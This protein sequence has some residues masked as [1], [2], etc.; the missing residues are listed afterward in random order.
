MQ[1][2]LQNITS[3]QSQARQATRRNWIDYARGIAIILVVFKHVTDG[4]VNM[5]ADINL[6][7]YDFC[8]LFYYARMPL[9][10]V[11]SGIYI[12]KSFEKRG[13]PGFIRYKFSTILY[14]YLVWATLQITFQLVANRYSVGN[15][16]RTALD[17]LY[18]FYQPHQLDQFWFLYV[19]FTGAVLFALLQFYFRLGKSAM[20]L[21]GTATYILFYYLPADFFVFGIKTV[22]KFLFYIALG[23]AI[24][25]T[26]LKPEN[27][28]KFSSLKLTA[29]FIALF[30]ALKLVMNVYE[31]PEQETDF[32][33]LQNALLLLSIF[34]GIAMILNISFVLDRFNLLVFLR[35]IGKHSLYI[36]TMH[37]IIN[38]ITRAILFKIGL[39]Q[40]P[41]IALYL[42]TAFSIGLPIL[43]YKL[44]N[45]WGLWFLYTPQKKTQNAL[46]V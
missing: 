41:N 15:T 38:G 35:K 13:L 28:D 6:G 30:A 10:F 5:Q 16:P 22:C 44:F 43:L 14:P 11:I 21:V 23:D 36:Y 4:L 8:K 26:M 1:P 19:L 33:S 37:I 9:F 12:R 46:T 3:T 34:S 7:P 17:Y 20:L 31:V 39:S 45:Q 27:F 40:Y 18:L 42:V 32:F 25:R 2:V 29:I 24:A